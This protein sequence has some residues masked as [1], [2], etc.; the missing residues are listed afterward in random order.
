[1]RKPI[2]VI[3]MRKPKEEAPS[4][5]NTAAVSAPT[6]KPLTTER[7]GGSVLGDVNG[8]GEVDEK[9]LSIVHKEYL[10]EKKKKKAAKKAK[11]V[12]TSLDV[13]NEKTFEKQGEDTGDI[14][15]D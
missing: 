4:L 3:K 6:E 1:M 10:K 11:K 12:N 15:T 13:A 5:P 9:D 8:D 2:S 14:V 7:D